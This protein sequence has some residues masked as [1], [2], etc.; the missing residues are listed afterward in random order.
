MGK[1][2]RQDEIVK[3]VDRAGT[4]TVAEIVECMKVSDMTVRRD[5]IELENKGFL[6]RVHGGAKSNQHLK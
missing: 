4:V 1:N 3:L 5:L 6:T 2:K